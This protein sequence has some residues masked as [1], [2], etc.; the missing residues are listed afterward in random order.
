MPTML[1]L[2]GNPGPYPW[3]GVK[4]WPR[5]ALDEP[6]ALEY[7]QLRGFAGKVLDVPGWN[8]E[9]SEQV[10]LAMKEINGDDSVTGLYGFS[11]GG[12]NLSI[13]LG[14]MTSEQKKRLSLVV[15]IGAPKM[16][17][18]RISGTWSVDYLADAPKEAGGH[19]GGPDYLLARWKNSNP[20]P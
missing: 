16:N 17:V 8:R 18:T 3:K 7:A 6:P 2:R 19:M 9:D 14:K 20:K 5:G 12:Y 4:T 1:I 11:A 15:A 13:I 10:K